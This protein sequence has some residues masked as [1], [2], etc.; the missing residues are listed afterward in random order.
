MKSHLTIAFLFLLSST[1]WA[2]D[3]PPARPA[4]EMLAAYFRAETASLAARCLADV[5]TLEQWTSHRDESRRQLAEMLGLWPMPE[6]TDLKPVITGKLDHAEFTVEK[7]HFQSRP[8]LYVTGDLYLPKGLTKPA[9]AILYVCG[10]GTV[11]KNGIAYG[12]KIPYQHHAAWFARNGY[13]CLIIDTLQLGEIEGIHHGTY[14]ENMWWWHSRGY[15]PAGVEAWNGIRSIDYLQSRPEVDGTKIGITGRSGGGAYSWWVAALDDRIKV[16][17]PVAGITD[18]QNYV[19]DGAIEGHCDCMFMVNTYRWDFA[20][21]AALVAP[22]PLLI[23]NSDK[24]TIFPLDGVVRLHEQVRRIYRLYGADDKLGLLI[25]EGLHKDTQELQIPAFRWFNRF[26]KGEQPII[27]M[28]AKPF[29]EPEQLKVF[30]QNPTDQLNTKIQETFVPMAPPPTVPESKEQWEKQRNAWLAAL[31]AQSFSGWPTTPG[32][33]NLKEVF[34]VKRHAL[35][36][37]AFDF[38][39]QENVPLRF[40][41]LSRENLNPVGFIALDVLDELGWQSNLLQLS[42]GFAADPKDIDPFPANE[43]SF[44]KTREI[45]LSSGLTMAFVVPRGI[46]PTAWTGDDK[47]QIQIRR[48]FALLGQTVDGMRVWDTRRAIQAIRTIDQFKAAPIGMTAGRG[49]AGV[50]L[51]ASLFEPNI[52]SLNLFLVPKSHQEGPDLLNVLKFMDMPSAV[53]LAAERCKVRL[54]GMDPADWSYPA[55][56]AAKLGW[57]EDRLEFPKKIKQ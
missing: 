24:D 10:H 52:N 7:L 50:A 25:T 26:L 34:S 53:A 32:D 12:A 6:K 41:L 33:L 14:R 54:L 20:Q 22:R 4:D 46:G 55:A 37:Q 15:T 39:S 21:V 30:T 47:K 49:M 48:R 28:A 27:E 40:I 9:P 29:F 23:S 16:V 51:Y 3:A 57:P 18:M 11:K 35:H 56:V 13:V 19:V 45:I 44:A 8:G 43:P 31:R 17:V 5:K 42:A 36:F 38:S 2:A 1:I